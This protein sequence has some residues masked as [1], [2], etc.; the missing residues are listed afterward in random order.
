MRQ[1]K[2]RIPWLIS[3][4]SVLL[5]G[6]DARPIPEVAPKVAGEGTAARSRAVADKPD[7]RTAITS[8]KN[9]LRPD[10]W[11]DDATRR[12]GVRFT[13][14]NGREAGRFYMIE[15]VGGGVAMIDFDGDGDLDLFFTGGGTISSDLP[16]RIAGLPSALYRNDGDWRFTEVT[17]SSELQ[18]FPDYSHGCAVADFDV[19]GFPDLFVGCYGRSR[20]YRNLGDGTYTEAREEARV[21]T[22]SWVT[23][24]A[25]GDIDRD[26]F[27]DLFLARYADWSPENE[28]ECS[29][30]E[31]VRD[32][33]GPRNYVGTTCRFFHN[34]GDGRFEDRSEQVGLEGNVRGLGVVAA[35]LNGDGWVD[36]FV[37]SDESPNHLYLGGPEIRFEESAAAAGVALNEVGNSQGS[38]GIDVGD[39]DGDGIP[40]LWLTNFEDE[41]DSLYRGMGDGLFIHATASVGLLGHTRMRSGWGTSLIDFDGDGWLDLFILNGN[42]FYRIGL[43]PFKQEP[44]LFRN[45]NGRRFENISGQGGT[46]F[47]ESCSGRGSA[48][49]DL[50]DDGAPDLATVAMNDPVRILRNRLLPRSYV[51]VEL[52]A[53]LGEPDATGARVTVEYHGRRLVRFAARGTSYFSQSDSRMIFP[54]DPEVADLEAV[55]DWPGRGRE[56]FRGLTVRKRHLLIEGRGE[57]AHEPP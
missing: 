53:R 57:T 49:G 7:A 13:Y 54:A 55:V 3:G 48:A 24:A 9:V 6:C 42:P 21:V 22:A 5:N 33:C 12:S 38:M 51:S 1:L 46:F 20:L 2:L 17:T 30:L 25:F 19:D 34:S 45:K 35:D 40:D 27:P 56:T 14:R 4:L 10:D 36:F 41:D 11:F 39:F 37:A 28:I 16:V 23:A 52:R 18:A 31:G 44:Q 29:S 50:D 43:T 26:G 15:S 8:E 47:R 32:L